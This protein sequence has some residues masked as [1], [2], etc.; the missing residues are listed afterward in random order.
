MFFYNTF[1]ANSCVFCSIYVIIYNNKNGGELDMIKKMIKAHTI[2]AC[3]YAVLNGALQP[4]TSGQTITLNEKVLNSIMFLSSNRQS[5]ELNITAMLP[6]IGT[7]LQAWFNAGNPLSFS[8][9]SSNPY[10]TGLQYKLQIIK[11]IGSTTDYAPVGVLNGEPSFEIF[12]NGISTGYYFGPNVTLF[13]IA[14]MMVYP[15]I[16]VPNGANNINLYTIPALGKYF[17]E[18]TSMFFIDASGQKS[19]VGPSEIAELNAQHQR[20]PQGAEMSIELQGNAQHFVNLFVGANSYVLL[21][22]KVPF[23]FPIKIY[24][25]NMLVATIES[26]LFSTLGSNGVLVCV[27]QK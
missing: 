18:I 1:D 24:I 3:L 5:T 26:P 13:T 12:C 23:S 4:L 9:S 15:A 6:A 7:S 22:N 8:V 16:N 14:P 17:S 21:P 20:L 11:S 25:N 27:L 19:L 10:G 2:F